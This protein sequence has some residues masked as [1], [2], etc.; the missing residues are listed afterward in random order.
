MSKYSNKSLSSTKSAM[1]PFLLAMLFF[2]GIH[3]IQYSKNNLGIK[4]GTFYDI[5]ETKVST[6]DLNLQI[7][8]HFD[9]A[10]CEPEEKEEESES[11]SLF[12]FFI[13]NNKNQLLIG[14]FQISSAVNHSLKKPIKA[15]KTPL[16]IL[17]RNFRVHLA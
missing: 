15:G 13:G 5:S 16:Y 7:V 4:P 6:P 9:F 17:F 14:F 1:Q 3:F 2:I 12:H 8:Q 10:S 11:E